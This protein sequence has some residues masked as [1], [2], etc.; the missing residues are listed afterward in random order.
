MAMSR[1]YRTHS[2]DCSARLR[3]FGGAGLQGTAPPRIDA[4]RISIPST[5]GEGGK[6]ALHFP[7]SHPRKILGGSKT[8]CCST[9]EEAGARS[10][11][12]AHGTAAAPVGPRAGAPGQRRRSYGR[13]TWRNNRVRSAVPVP[14]GPVA[15]HDMRNRPA[16][17]GP[18]GRPVASHHITRQLSGAVKECD[19]I[20]TSTNL[21]YA[22]AVTRPDGTSKKLERAAGAVTRH[23]HA[24][25]V[26][27]AC[28]GAGGKSIGAWPRSLRQA[29]RG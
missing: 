12:P 22:P 27:A 10:C 5:D 17:P 1:M 4:F 21:T 11:A 25:E 15:P 2:V 18:G 7:R 3:L 8:V 14:A 20:N 23:T 6:S 26:V 19:G 13:V 24:M 29:D 9:V 28:A 16:R